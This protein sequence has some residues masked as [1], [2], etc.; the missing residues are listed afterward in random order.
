MITQAIT[1]QV[2]VPPVT[3]F[4]PT[5]DRQSIQVHMQFMA[6][7]ALHFSPIR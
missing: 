5:I 7:K 2:D 1:G 6:I 4:T 3:W